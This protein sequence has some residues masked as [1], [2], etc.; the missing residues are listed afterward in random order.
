LAEGSP[1]KSWT[2]VGVA[3]AGPI[4]ADVEIW[5]STPVSTAVAPSAGATVAVVTEPRRAMFTPLVVWPAATVADAVPLREV[6][7]TFA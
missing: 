5:I 1:W 2:F 4:G 3:V 7:G 6:R